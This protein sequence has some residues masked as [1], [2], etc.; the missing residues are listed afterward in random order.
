MAICFY[1]YYDNVRYFL[2]VSRD[3]NKGKNCVQN[4]KRGKINNEF[5]LLNNRKCR[6]L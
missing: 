6:L 4:S 5:I 3:K 2:Y 1:C